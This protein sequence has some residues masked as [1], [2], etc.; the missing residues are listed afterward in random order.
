MD[1]RADLDPAALTRTLTRLD[2][3]RTDREVVLD[4]AAGLDDADLARLEVLVARLDE[5]FDA[6]IDGRTVTVFEDGDTHHR[7]GPGA[8]VVLALA[9]AAPGLAQRSSYPSH[10][11]RDTQADLGQQ[12][13]CFRAIH[14]ETGLDV[15]WWM[16]V[17]FSNGFARLGRL[18]Y[19]VARSDVGLGGDE[20][21]VLAIH[22]PGDGPLKS[23]DVDDSLIRACTFFEE[24]HPQLAPIDWFTC[25]SWLLDPGVSWESPRSNIAQFAGRFDVW[26]IDDG[27]R[28]ALEYVFDTK[29]A[30]DQDVP[31][32]LDRLP[33]DTSLR[34][35]VVQ[36][37]RDGEHVMTC[38][39]R[40]PVIRDVSEEE[41][42]ADLA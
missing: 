19:E 25:R 7:L 17:V 35:T 42:G 12:M 34:R 6:R 13:R 9:L 16:E 38:S 8:L 18:Q 37:W 36:H 29:P 11:V 23:D 21:N 27:D 14:D 3:D 10:V 31:G 32:D 40:I 22:V 4:W 20:V 33:T 26:R 28:E 15:A 30:D 24:H 1:L 41:A 2:L 39:G 5:A